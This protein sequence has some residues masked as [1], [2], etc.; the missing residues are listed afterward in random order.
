MRKELELLTTEACSRGA[1]QALVT[2]PLAAARVLQLPLRAP[3]ELPLGTP[4]RKIPKNLKTRQK[5]MVLKLLFDPEHRNRTGKT[6]PG[7][8]TERGKP[9]RD[10]QPNWENR[11]G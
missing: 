9:D 6:G 11:T 8:G 5:S 2:A 1:K 7:S 10:M 4:R 3:Q